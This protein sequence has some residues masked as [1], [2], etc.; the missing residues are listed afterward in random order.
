M[1]TVLDSS[2]FGELLAIGSFGI[3]C[4][5]VLLWLAI[6]LFNVGSLI[7]VLMVALI[8]VVCQGFVC[9]TD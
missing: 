9:N 1:L 3:I 5:Y 2:I 4:P 8:E 6:N 7:L